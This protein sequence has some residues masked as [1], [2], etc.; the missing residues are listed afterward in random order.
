MA[1]MVTKTDRRIM[2]YL[3]E[4]A[5]MPDSA[6]AK[7]MS[8]SKQ[9]I[10]YRLKRLE[11]LNALTGYRAKINSSLLGFSTFGV[12][13][14]LNKATDE[15]FLVDELKKSPF[16]R[17]IVSCTG[18]WDIIFSVSAR[19]IGHFNSILNKI[20]IKAEKY[21]KSYDTNIFLYTKDFISE[22]LYEFGHKDIPA[23]KEISEGN[24]IKIDKKDVML[25]DILQN[26]ARMPILLISRKLGISPYAARY[27]I[28]SLIK[29]GIINQFKPSINYE[30]L[31]YGWYQ[32]LIHTKNL[33]EKEEKD[34]LATLRTIKGITYILKCIGKW[35][36][37]IIMNVQDNWK[38]RESLLELRTKLS[39]Y[40][41]SYDTLIVF[42]NYK[43]Q[44]LPEGVI[45]EL[46]KNS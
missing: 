14:Q 41:L 6:I 1:K 4:N 18:K 8:T 39:D 13:I 42:R 11:K 35:N 32:I 23:L 34:F 28:K 9:V 22:L 3:L 17:W 44:T 24:A 19:D 15:K 20:M 5:R 25:L 46:I 33:S 21:I 30:A 40:I 43:R 12:Y 27:R 16:I 37:E 45:A 31:G 38:F 36:F 29:S 10:G 7:K 2:Y 26:T